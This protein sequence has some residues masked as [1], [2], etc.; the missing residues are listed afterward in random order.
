MVDLGNCAY[1]FKATP[2]HPA[3]EPIACYF[4]FIPFRSFCRVLT[5]LVD[6]ERMDW[7]THKI[8]RSSVE[9][10]EYDLNWDNIASCLEHV[11][12]MERF[13]SRLQD[14]FNEKLSE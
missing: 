14:V 5:A 10:N 6:F 8:K 2:A 13:W 7:D 9:W 12:E 4:V 1:C 3:F 11:N